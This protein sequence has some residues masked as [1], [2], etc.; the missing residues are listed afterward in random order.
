VFLNHNICSFQVDKA[1]SL[2]ND[3]PDEGNIETM[4]VDE[5][6]EST[7]QLAEELKN[8]AT[9]ARCLRCH[10]IQNLRKVSCRLTNNS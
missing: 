9:A 5:Q 10:L 8:S 7:D 4:E 1:S 3:S 6:P 2:K